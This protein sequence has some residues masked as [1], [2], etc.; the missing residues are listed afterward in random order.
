[1]EYAEGA[2]TAAGL[3]PKK[4]G[5][6]GSAVWKWKVGSHTTKGSWPTPRVWPGAL[7]VEGGVVGTWGRAKAVVTVEPWQVFTATQ[8]GRDRSRSRLDADA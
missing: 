5:T 1:M 2:S 6:T 3:E 8:R 7:L 4:A